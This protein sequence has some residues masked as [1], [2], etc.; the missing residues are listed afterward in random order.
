MSTATIDN[1][2]AAALA[3]DKMLNFFAEPLPMWLTVR[4]AAQV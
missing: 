4:P 2:T 3:S 1:L